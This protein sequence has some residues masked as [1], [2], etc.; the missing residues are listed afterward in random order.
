MGKDSRGLLFNLASK[1]LCL[2]LEGQPR[3]RGK[4]LLLGVGRR[5]KASSQALGSLLMLLPHRPEQSPL[6][7]AHGNINYPRPE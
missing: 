6:A 3:Q 2:W 5:S 4:T 7:L 1:T